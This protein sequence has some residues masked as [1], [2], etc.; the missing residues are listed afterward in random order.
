MSCYMVLLTPFSAVKLF[1][2]GPIPA[3]WVYFKC[4][5]V[6]IKE[7]IECSLIYEHVVTGIISCPIPANG[8]TP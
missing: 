8:N 3:F 5:V 4:Q 1:L 2:L 7:D 6:A